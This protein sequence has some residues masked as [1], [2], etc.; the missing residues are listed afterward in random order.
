MQEQDMLMKVVNQDLRK[1]NEELEQFAHIA[2][3]DLQEPLRKLQQFS[4]L[5]EEDYQDKL[6]EDGKFFLDT[7]RNSA[8]RM[9]VLIRETLAYSRAGSSN[10][11]LE[12][13]DLSKL[14]LQLRDEMDV[15]MREAQADI[16]IHSLPMVM[17]NSLGMAQLFRNL[18]INALKYRKPD[19]PAEIIIGTQLDVSSS[20]APKNTVSITV[21]DNGIGIDE[22]YLDRIFAPFERLHSSKIQGTGLG[23]AICRKVCDSH[24]WRL[25]VRSTLG[26]GTT[27]EILLPNAHLVTDSKAKAHSTQSA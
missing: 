18:M 25:N 9:S 27:F 1:A 13:V 15:A 21:Q 19:V 16:R 11:T 6:D 10:Q 17:A 5:L 22:K 3:H 20:E 23:L 8:D 12:V 24:G 2:S 14:T 26:Q 4:V 7:I